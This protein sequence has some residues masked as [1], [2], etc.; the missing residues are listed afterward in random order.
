MKTIR[1]SCIGS[2]DITPESPTYELAFETGK[3]LA[4][5]G[6]IVV[7]GGL[8][9]VME[10]VCRGAK[11]AGGATVGIVPTNNPA[12]ANPWVDTPVATGLGPMR[13][14][15]VVINGDAVL[16]FEGGAGTRSE[17]ALSQK[18]GKEVVALAAHPGF[19]DLTRAETPAEA[20]RMLADIV[21]R[22]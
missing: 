11:E 21:S 16:A 18:T 10:A 8:R 9:G 5:A 15:L 14:Y 6:W 7:C 13:N 3:L 17:L 22:R 1:I 12:D 19:D 4:H 2:G 20:V